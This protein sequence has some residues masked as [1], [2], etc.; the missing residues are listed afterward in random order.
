MDKQQAESKE[1]TKIAREELEWQLDHH[2]Q[3]AEEEFAKIEL[4][5]KE[6][7]RKG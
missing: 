3:V 7:L 5:R 6:L 1:Q 2:E 4:E